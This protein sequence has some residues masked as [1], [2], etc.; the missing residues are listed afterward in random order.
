MSVADVTARL[1]GVTAMCWAICLVGAGAPAALAD[2]CPNAGLR[3]G[4]SAG[5]PDCRAYEMVSPPDKNNNDIR[6]G[7]NAVA[8]DG[9]GLTYWSLGSFA[10]APA[11]AGL[12][13]YLSRRTRSG[14]STTGL[15]LPGAASFNK[16]VFGYSAFSADLRAMVVQNQDPGADGAVP[17]TINLYRRDDDG[18]LH[19][20]TPG[21]HAPTGQGNPPQNDQFVSASADLTHVVFAEQDALLPGDPAGVVNLYESANGVLRLVSVLPDGTPDPDG[22]GGFNA[23]NIVSSDGARIFWPGAGSS[24]RFPIYVRENGTTT[25]QI[26]A[27]QRSVPDPD[28]TGA[29]GCVSGSAA[30]YWTAATDGANAFITSQEKL[31]DDATACLTCGIENGADL[32]RYDVGSGRL[33]DLTVDLNGGDVAGADVQGVVG[34]SDDGNTVYFVA[35]GVLAA[36]ASPGDC[37]EETGGNACNLYVWHAG[38]TRFVATVTTQPDPVNGLSDSIDWV[39]GVF[40]THRSTRVQVTPD[41][42]HLM[43][44]TRAPQPGFDNAGHSEV[45]VYD[46]AGSGSLR[47]VSC[48]PGGVAA[49]SAVPTAPA[50][51]DGGSAPNAIYRNISPDGRRAFFTS[52]DALVPEDTNGT[53][54]VYEWQDGER[55][56]ISTGRNSSQSTFL[57][58][59]SSG[60]DVFFLTRE[61]LVGQDT[62]DD[63]DVYDARVGGG[64]ASQ[65]PV[66]VPLCSGD[67]CREATPAPPAAPQPASGSFTGSGNVV[68]R[69]ESFRL[70]AI[71]ASARRRFARTGVLTLALR[72]SAPG[73]VSARATATIARRT[74][75][76]ASKSAQVSKAE[77]VHLRL[78]LSAT[79]RREL[80]RK[81]R[82]KLA[83]TVTYSRALDAR[84]IAFTLDR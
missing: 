48:D 73:S 69:R 3:A 5:L 10:G 33:A 6:L 66:A 56:L 51:A 60:D 21:Q 67:D 19:L 1:L 16:D 8:L 58:A 57:G 25:T 28:C 84:H 7:T 44:T 77:T 37:F 42:Q 76:V 50:D 71:T 55:H 43:F 74:R 61:Q 79:A 59:T 34:A 52:A 46:A 24:N 36:G 82:L 11:A 27:S 64:L 9:N 75:T 4:A 29:N 15:T 47:C 31:T 17:G 22:V 39:P 35:N 13:Q 54:D 49:G 65:N 70:S 41:G 53:T 62:D 40:P 18:S 26:S 30:Q 78:V 83:I 38:T 12:D 32:Y 63:V 23:A 80:A 81:R 45:Y 2:S 14:W 20:L 72:V 68:S